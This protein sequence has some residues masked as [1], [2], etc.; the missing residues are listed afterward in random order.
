MRSEAAIRRVERRVIL[1]LRA[2]VLWPD[3]SPPPPLTRD[4]SPSSRHWAA[5]LGGEVV[6]CVS[7]MQLRGFAL[8]A[9]AVAP[10]LQGQG[11]GARL[12]ATVCRQ[13]GEPMWC[14]ARLGVVGFYE[15]QGWRRVGPVFELS[16]RGA[17]QRM[18]W[19]PH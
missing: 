7:V 15:R 17:H 5:F 1:P 4:R 11:L 19:A 14:N 10:E 13:V 6:G 18:T 9:M 3:E 2:R 12:L 8:R 16:E